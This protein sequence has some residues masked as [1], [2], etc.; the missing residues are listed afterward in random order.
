MAK[1]R[2]A[3]GIV[4]V[5]VVGGREGESFAS[6]AE[7]RDR[8]EAAC[9]AEGIRLTAVHEEMD[10][11]G[12]RPLAG[13]DGLRAAIEAVEAGKAEVVIAAYLDRLCRSLDVQRQLIERVEAAGGE[14]RALDVG[15]VSHKTAT[16]KLSA[17]LLGAFAEY[18]RDRARENARASHA[19][20]IA[21]GV[22][23]WPNIIPGYRR[24]P[25]EV[26]V[27]YPPE[28][29]AVREA[30]R[31]RAKGAPIAKVREYLAGQG[32]ERSEH[33]VTSLVES[34]VVLGELVFGELSN[35][36]A[37]EAIVDRD[38]WKRAQEATVPRG[39]MAPSSALLARLGVLRCGECGGRMTVGTNRNGIYPAYRCPGKSEADCPARFSISAT[40]A[41][42]AIV[43]ATRAAIADIEGR[44]DGQANRR[45]AEADLASA[46]SAL[47]AAV[48]AFD[49]LGD[50]QVA[51]DK[52][53]SLRASVDE[54]R[55]RLERL[56]T[57]DVAIRIN[58]AEEWDKLTPDEQRELI[59]ATIKTAVVG[60]GRG[61]ERITITSA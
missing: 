18:Q 14:V 29:G 45:Q 55:E 4:R 57:A 31:M 30:F 51:K 48:S 9:K 61:A 7:Q 21:R 2:R 34:R 13:R 49:G 16:T 41:E 33:G 60:P 39:R 44:A 1:I 59:R 20:A 6:P 46:E 23:P 27:P 58:G 11:S 50:L 19:R 38:T 22:P 56:G 3:I 17:T 52:L 37:H 47:E 15:A 26:L 53:A 25:D 12:G 42:Q 35:P 54:A 5:S 8:I 32:I 36:V 28:V 10:V 43:A 40:F 24:G